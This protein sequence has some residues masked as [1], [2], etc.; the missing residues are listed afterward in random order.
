MIITME[1]VKKVRE[2]TGAGINDVKK[3]LDEAGGD[4]VKAVEYLRKQGKKIAAK[5]ADRSV[6]EGVIAVK[7]EG[8]KIALVELY[9]E[10]DFVA[11]N[12]DFLKFADEFA[13]K[14][15]KVGKDEFAAWAKDEIQN[16]LIV[17]IGEN[18]Q[19]GKFEIITGEVLGT[20]LH[21]N[22]KIASVVVLSS[23]TEELAKEVAMQVTAMNP[24]Y[25]KAGDIPSEVIEKEKEIY[26]EQLKN[27]GKPEEMVEKIL[28]GKLK[29]YYTEVC[30]LNQSFVKDDKVSIE[31]LL[32]GAE[33]K[34]FIR[35]SL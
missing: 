17:K 10:T 14:L 3:A 31:K 5:K 25:L 28:E 33:V 26:R 35:F 7:Q 18:I 4:E 23:G 11:R 24:A 34:Q 19:L 2:A 29:K 21:S 9:C 12:G 6:N 22:K 15:L 1:L 13:G 8:N 16:N 30:L 27:E 32:N 20:Y